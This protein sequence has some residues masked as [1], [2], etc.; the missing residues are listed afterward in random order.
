[1][2]AIREIEAMLNELDLFG[3]TAVDLTIIC[4]LHGNVAMAE[5]IAAAAP[6][7]VR[8]PEDPDLPLP[9]EAPWQR[10]KACVS[11]DE[12][13]AWAQ[14][15]FAAMNACDQAMTDRVQA[16]VVRRCAN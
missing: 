9:D 10:L 5:A 2:K 3:R 14:F 7:L 13:H 6:G 12:H 8:R 4:C 16:L 11:E 1:M 15:M